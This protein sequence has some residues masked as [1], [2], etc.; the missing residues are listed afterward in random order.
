MRGSGA[1]YNWLGGSKVMVKAL[2]FDADV[3]SKP[4]IQC[5]LQLSM[6]VQI[7]PTSERIYII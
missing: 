4:D 7:M 2:L 5:Q 6:S 1:H 3:L